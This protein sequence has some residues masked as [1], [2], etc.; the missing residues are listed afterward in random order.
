MRA[1]EDLGRRLIA[2][3]ALVAALWFGAK[4]LLFLLAPFFAAYALAA[5]MEGAVR[6][7]VRRGLP[8]RMA[9][10]LTT[11]LALGLIG[12][13]LWLLVGRLSGL[14][15]ALGRAAPRLVSALGEKMNALEEHAARFAAS[16]PEGFPDPLRTALD[17]AGSALGA[18]PAQLSSRLLALAAGA[19][20]NAP[21]IL[22]FL[23]SLFLGAYLI[24]AS[25]PEV[26]G[27]IRA[28]APE[29]AR[30]RAA[31]LAEDLRGSLGGW[32]RAQLILAGLCFFELLG[33][34]L[35]L[36]VRSAAP[37]AAVTAFIDAL[38][39]FGAG[40]ILVPWA[41]AELLLGELGR[42]L[43]L[44]FGWAL[45]A[46]GRNLLQARLLSGQI[47]IHPLV[48]LVSI[49]AGWRVWGV[50]GMIVF[51]LLFAM[52]Q[53]LVERGLLAPDVFRK[54]SPRAGQGNGK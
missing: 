16:M 10:A 40:I 48:S 2:V 53:R 42:G 11:L 1:W 50:W 44:L 45:G 17:S 39:V 4:A 31:E 13:L 22:L 41:L 33:L 30:R 51:P 47:G 12:A 6:V 9:S 26:I 37:L 20:Q 25:Y 27:F 46:L 7:L 49:Y 3:A 19:M 21:G 43:A 32:L 18:L 23:I 36:G 15:A 35:L 52:L 38:P 34:F 29:K 28:R 8:R 14:L 5:A 24:S 54:A